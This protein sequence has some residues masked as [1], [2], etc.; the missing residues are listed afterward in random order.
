MYL[1]T[2]CFYIQVSAPA[3]LRDVIEEILQRT[4]HQKFHSSA[5][6]LV[7]FCLHVLNGYQHLEVD[8]DG[9]PRNEHYRIILSTSLPCW[10]S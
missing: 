3:A 5:K 4:V 6:A 7:Q 8:F 2:F 10:K 1:G 9:R